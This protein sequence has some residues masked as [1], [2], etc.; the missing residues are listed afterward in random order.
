MVSELVFLGQKGTNI[1]LQKKY[2]RLIPLETTHNADMAELLLSDA[3][4][5]MV[6][7]AASLTA[8]L[9]ESL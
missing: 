9:S 7:K 8:W 6:W 4:Y 2:T 1:A 5:L 3:R